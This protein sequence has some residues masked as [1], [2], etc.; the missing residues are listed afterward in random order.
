MMA[1]QD[2]NS[3]KKLQRENE[4]K[5]NRYDRKIKSNVDGRKDLWGFF[6]ELIEMYMPRILNTIL[7]ISPTDWEEE[8]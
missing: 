7:G 2:K 4:S 8:E 6:G 3:F 1:E 5:F